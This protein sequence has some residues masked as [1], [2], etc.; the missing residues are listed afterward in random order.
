MNRTLPVSLVLLL[1]S[2]S[3]FGWWGD[4]C[5]FRADRSLDIDAQGLSAIE[6]LARAGDLEVTGDPGLTAIEVRGKACAEDESLLA[7][8]KLAERRD[9][10]RLLIEVVIPDGN[11]WVD[12][13]ASMDLVVRVPARL[14]LELQDSSGDVRVERVASL[15]ATD[16]GGRDIKVPVA[17]S[18]KSWRDAREKFC[19]VF[20]KIDPGM[21][22]GGANY[23]RLHE[24]ARRALLLRKLGAAVG[25][26]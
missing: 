14:N 21:F 12:A 19:P 13:Q 16:S 26:H 7:G 25:E 11:G 17:Q 6:I 3:A 5:E 9:G 10:D 23:C 22:V 15:K 2:T 24:T 8:V 1:S 4:G 18:Q 20:D